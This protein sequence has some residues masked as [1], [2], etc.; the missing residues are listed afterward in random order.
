MCV[1]V[2][3]G[4]PVTLCQELASVLLGR[5]VFAVNMVSDCWGLGTYTVHWCVTELWSGPSWE[6]VRLFPRDTFIHSK[7]LWIL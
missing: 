4:R 6:G 5:L 2:D 3:Q 1:H 7:L